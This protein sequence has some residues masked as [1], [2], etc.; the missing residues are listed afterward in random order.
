MMIRIKF[1][2]YWIFRRLCRYFFLLSNTFYFF[3]YALPWLK[4]HGFFKGFFSV[5]FGYQS[6]LVSS[7][8]V[9][10]KIALSKKSKIKNEYL[11]YL[12]IKNTF[13][14]LAPM[15][16]NY[17]ILD[18]WFINALLCERMTK[19]ESSKAPPL[20][21]FIYE[22]LGK[23]AVLDRKLTLQDCPQIKAGLDRLAEDYDEKIVR[24]LRVIAEKFLLSSWYTSGMAHGDFHSRNIMKDRFGNAKLIDLDC[25]RVKAV[26]EFDPLYFALEQVWSFSGEDWVESLSNCLGGA[27]GDVV[28]CLESFGVKWSGGLGVVFFLD[29]LGQD[30]MNYGIVYSSN[31]LNRLVN[32]SLEIKL[33]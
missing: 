29:R 14:Y 4:L 2:F 25:F 9:F 10:I 17:Q 3:L 19:V 12:S 1:F 22:M 16:P 6:I 8:D 33:G 27:Q 28:S 26:R 21:I 18:G 13:P 7:K 31:K 32:A 24:Q 20:A 5:S 23:S 15:L 11:N 30:T